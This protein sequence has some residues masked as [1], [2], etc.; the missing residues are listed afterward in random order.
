M[1][2]YMRRK[3]TLTV[4]VVVD[5]ANDNAQALKVGEAVVSLPA[6]LPAAHAYPTVIRSAQIKSVT[7]EKV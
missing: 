3:V 7:V 5:G 6:E 1:P 2:E 4:E